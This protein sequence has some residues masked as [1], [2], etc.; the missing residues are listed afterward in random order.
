VE[1]PAIIAAATIATSTSEFLNAIEGLTNLYAAIILCV[2]ALVF[3]VVAA[4]V[5]FPVFQA[6]VLRWWIGG[7]RL[8]GL[9]IHSK[10]RTAPIYGGYLRFLGYGLLFAVA[11][12]VAGGLA[13]ALSV[14][15]VADLSNGVLAEAIN[16]FIAVGFYVITMLGFS[17]IYQVTVKLTLWRAGMES[18]ALEGAD[19]LERVKAEGALSSAVGEGLADALN[20][21]GI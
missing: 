17:A 10:L 20:M 16:A 5:L 21:G 2:S 9:T 14:F 15:V 12:L 1:W 4:A 3:S 19:V 6:M 18:I 11:L 7:L 8:G 13:A